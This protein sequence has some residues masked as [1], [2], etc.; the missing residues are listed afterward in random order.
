M[1]TVVPAA[2]VG[3]GRACTHSL[4]VDHHCCTTV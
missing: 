2:A 1:V 3:P 4:E